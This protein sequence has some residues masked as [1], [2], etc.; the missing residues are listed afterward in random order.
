MEDDLILSSEMEDDLNNFRNG[1]RPEKFQ[2]WKTTSKI[3]KMEDNLNFSKMEDKKN[4]LFL[5][6]LKFKGKPFLGLAQ[7]SKI[8]YY[9]VTASRFYFGNYNSFLLCNSFHIY[10]SFLGL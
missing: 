5:I 9:Y 8:F 2:K 1:R 7:L 3:S 6:S 10:N 4:H